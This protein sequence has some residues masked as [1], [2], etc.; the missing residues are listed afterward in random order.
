[1]FNSNARLSAVGR[2][3]T[4]Y[5]ALCEALIHLAKAMPADSVD[6]SVIRL[7]T[8]YDTYSVLPCYVVSVECSFGTSTPI[9]EWRKGE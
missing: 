4:E 5:E 9:N 7:H 6:H 8:T 2:G 3:D 1:M